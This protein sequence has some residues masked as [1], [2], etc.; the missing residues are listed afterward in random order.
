MLGDVEAKDTGTGFL[1]LPAE[2]RNRIYH[3]ALTR[4]DTI[5]VTSFDIAKP[6]FNS[7]ATQPALTQICRQIRNEALP[8]FYNQNCFT[9][10]YVADEEVLEHVFA[11]WVLLE[12]S[13]EEYLVASGWMVARLELRRRM[14]SQLWNRSLRSEGGGLTERGV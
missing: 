3:L 13:I 14:S 12:R 10:S 1:D 8:V 2:L 11:G 5:N 6:Q 9:G 4:P 7:S